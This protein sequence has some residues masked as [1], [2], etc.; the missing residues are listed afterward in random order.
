MASQCPVKVN[1]ILLVHTCQTEGACNET[2][3][4]MRVY[5]YI[6]RGI[7]REICSMWHLVA[8]KNYWERHGQIETV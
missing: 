3:N 4:N 8:Y 5:I 7:K 1:K 2:Y 6:E